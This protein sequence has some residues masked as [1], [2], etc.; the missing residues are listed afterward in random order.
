MFVRV[1]VTL[2]TAIALP[3]TVNGTVSLNCPPVAFEAVLLNHAVYADVSATVIWDCD[4]VLPL[5]TANVKLPLDTSRVLEYP[6]TT[7]LIP[8]VTCWSATEVITGTAGS[9][10]IVLTGAGAG[11]M[12]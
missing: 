10:V 7:T 3:V 4:N 12:F 6:V 8:P 9:I 2:V 11:V 5:D 1:T